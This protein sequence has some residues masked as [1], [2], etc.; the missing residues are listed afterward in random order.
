MD[1][2]LF[3]DDLFYFGEFRETLL[4]Y[5]NFIHEYLTYLVF[6]SYSELL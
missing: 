4:F 3:S 6:K 1:G 5:S 2:V